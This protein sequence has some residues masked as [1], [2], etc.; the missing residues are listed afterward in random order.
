MLV[1]TNQAGDV[2]VTGSNSDAVSVTEHISFHGTAPTTTHRA[3]AGTLSLE[4]R[5]PA[6]ETCGVD[7]TITAPRTV[8][9][10]VTDSTG[11]VTLDSLGGP[12][13][14]HVKAGKIS[15]S[16]LAGSVEATSSAGSIE[17]HR[18]SSANA[19]L[20]V[21]AG[22]IGVTFTAPATSITATTDVGTI[23]LR[24]PATVQ[25]NVRATATVGHVRVRISRNPAAA[26]TITAST[27]TGSITIEPT[28]DATAAS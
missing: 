20:H 10:R 26:R 2:H 14:V 6:A 3:A 9:V 16:S 13:T 21:S 11:T 8:T 15:L 27:K 7:Y 23:T 18:L 1:V 5:C 28:G 22:Q 19:S 24:V 25:Y 12:V 4:S 17:G